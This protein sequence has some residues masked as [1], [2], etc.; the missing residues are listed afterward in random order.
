MLFLKLRPVRVVSIYYLLKYQ[1][2]SFI[3][4][5]YHCFLQI[6]RII[7]KIEEKIAQKNHL[8]QTLSNYWTRQV[9]TT[10]NQIVNRF[11]V[12]RDS[13]FASWNTASLLQLIVGCINSWISD[14]NVKFTAGVYPTRD[15][16]L[17]H[18]WLPCLPWTTWWERD[19]LSPI[20]PHPWS[21]YVK[22]C[23]SSLTIIKK[24]YQYRKTLDRYNV[25]FA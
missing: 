6:L 20:T 13:F 23:L 15:M 24:I 12:D 4:Q 8:K 17:I 11:N 2:K 7:R 19:P 1:N 5:R 3:Y 9:M 16:D 25:R 22:A 21:I 10:S 14:A 18:F